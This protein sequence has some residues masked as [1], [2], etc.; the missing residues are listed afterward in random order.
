MK[1]VFF[2]IDL[3]L[4]SCKI[5]IQCDSF[6]ILNFTTKQ[7][8]RS[9]CAFLKRGEGGARVITGT[10]KIPTRKKEK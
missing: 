10:D 4:Y 6:E 2:N 7:D 8:L 9:I 3:I 5:P 1:L